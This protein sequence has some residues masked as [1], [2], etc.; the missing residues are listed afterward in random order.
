MK[1]NS[2]RKVTRRGNGALLDTRELANALGE[3]ERTIRS[4]R[5]AGIIPVIQCGYR[6]QRFKLPD[7][8]DALERRTIRALSK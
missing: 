3:N 4:W 5:A 2:D 1:T 8:M 7:V 6:T